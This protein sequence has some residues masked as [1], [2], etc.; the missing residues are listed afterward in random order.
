[1]D[2]THIEDNSVMVLT[3]WRCSAPMVAIIWAEPGVMVRCACDG[4]TRLPS[5]QLKFEEWA[6]AKRGDADALIRLGKEHLK[7]EE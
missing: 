1:M 4:W 5:I 3:C 6:R 7:Q 2:T